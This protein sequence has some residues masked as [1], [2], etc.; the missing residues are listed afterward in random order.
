MC[1]LETSSIYYALAG[2]TAVIISDHADVAYAMSG[3]P[4]K[5]SESGRMGKYHMAYLIPRIIGIVFLGMA[6]HARHMNDI[7]VISFYAACGLGYVW[8]SA[9]INDTVRR[10]LETR[11]FTGASAASSIATV[12]GVAVLY[13]LSV[14]VFVVE[15]EKDLDEPYKGLAIWAP[16]VAFIMDVGLF[17]VR[18][19]DGIMG[20][21]ATFLHVTQA[22][23]WIVTAFVLATRC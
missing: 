10:V 13:V 21:V 16:F 17:V 11:E 5:A 4:I 12:L 22:V 20:V 2:A 23:V 18:T 6:L 15:L 3:N 14:S 7:A 19:R 1:E 9:G 8:Y